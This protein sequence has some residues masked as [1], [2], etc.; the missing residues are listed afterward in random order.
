MPQTFK[1]DQAATFANMIA[2]SSAPKLKFGSDTDQECTKD[3]TPKWEVQVAAGFYSFGKV[4]NEVLKIG[5]AAEKDPSEG[6]QLYAPVELV[7]FEVGVMEKTGKDGS[8]IGF[9]VWYRADEVRSTRATGPST[10]AAASAPAA[11]GEAATGK[12]KG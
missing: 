10:P 4:T 2:L 9:Q 1:V 6:F 3:G 8:P 12:A 11:N 7:G 5:V